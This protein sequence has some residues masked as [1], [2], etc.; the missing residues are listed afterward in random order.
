[1]M[2]RAE[3][4]YSNPELKR[5]AALAVESPQDIDTWI[6]GLQNALL[7]T[8]D[9]T[10]ENSVS[11]MRE[12]MMAGKVKRAEEGKMPSGYI[13]GYKN[14][15][16]GNFT[17]V[18]DQAE[19][20]MNIF[21]L[22]NKLKNLGAVE[23]ELKRLGIKTRGGKKWT[24]QAIVNTLKSPLYCGKGFWWRGELIET[25]IPPIVTKKIWDKAQRIIKSRSRGIRKKND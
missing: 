7:E 17:I 24:R 13:I 11:H 6:E 12:R 16:D 9:E 14:D 10:V 2:T 22:Y 21:N 1:V 5:F 4:F 19:T 18:K 3:K 15:E 20:V 25:D 8:A 23:R